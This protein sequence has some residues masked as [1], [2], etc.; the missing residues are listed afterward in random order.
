MPSISVIVPVFNGQRFL[1]E[2]L[3]SVFAQTQLP[4]E[5]IVVDDGSTDGSAAVARSFDGVRCIRM[6]HAGQGAALNAGVGA[7]RG[8]LLAFLD[9][10]DRWLPDKLARQ[11]AALARNPELELLFG[12]ARQFVEST[13]PLSREI[14]GRVLPARLPS[15]MIVRRAA[16]ERVGAFSTEWA[17]GGVVEWCLRAEEVGIK[18]EVLDAL[19]YERRIHRV[20]PSMPWSSVTHEY[21]RMLKAVLDRRRSLA[22]AR[23]RGSE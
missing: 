10:D 1:A 21:A 19:V 22:L 9:A 11:L 23:A 15:A 18:S 14:D 8:D 6:E 13:S 2:T 5:V 7:S 3:T 17:L 20:N 4:D 16:W 12:H